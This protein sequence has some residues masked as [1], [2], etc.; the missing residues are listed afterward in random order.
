MFRLLIGVAIGFVL[1]SAA[2]RGRY[3]KIKATATDVVNKP[4]VQSALKKADDFIADKA[5]VLHDVGEAAAEAV[6]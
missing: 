2:G 6:S 3:E 1:G 4:E 5:P